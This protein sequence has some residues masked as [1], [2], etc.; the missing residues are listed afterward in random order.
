MFELC[1]DVLAS[2][3]ATSQVS[4]ESLPNFGTEVA[5]INGSVETLCI[6]QGQ[7]NVGLPNGGDPGEFNQE[8][9]VCDEITII[10]TLGEWA[11]ISLSIL[12]LIFGIV[13]IRERQVS[14]SRSVN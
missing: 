11:L 3:G 9:V 12:F 7:V 8:I 2:S 4:L 6:Q 5:N 10:P 1:F 14:I 13:S